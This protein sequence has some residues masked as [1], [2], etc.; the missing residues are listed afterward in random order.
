LKSNLSASRPISGLDGIRALAVVSVIA[1]H[2]HV[3]WLGGGGLGV[4]IFFTLSGFLITTLLL[5][6]RAVTG[7]VSLAKFWGRRLLRLMP[8]LL[9]M[10][11]LVDTVGL[12]IGSELWVNGL[13]ATPSVIFYFAN[14][15]AVLDGGPA[16]LGVFAPL[17]SLS[18]E[19]QF[20][21]VWPLVVMVCAS[22]VRSRRVLGIVGSLIALAAIVNRF[23]LFDGAARDRTFGTDFRIDV[24]LAGALLA[25][26][27]QSG[28]VSL[29]R[30]ASRFAVVPA[31]L[32]LVGAACFLPDV[33]AY[34]DDATAYLYYTVG[35]PLIALSTACIVGF[36]TTHQ[37]SRMVRVLSLK[38]LT[39]LGR[40]SYGMYLWHFPIMVVVVSA[41]HLD[42]DLLFVVS[43]VATVV[44]A[45][46]SWRFVER[47]LS[48]QFHSRLVAQPRRGP[49]ASAEV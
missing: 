23:V 18:V 21:F 41:L 47:P 16:A 38:P 34:G 20:Y 27:M 40:I 28:K 39:Y 2:A 14:W 45:S 11:L 6:E 8:A 7:R 3:V 42:P 33:H 46:L 22:F 29:V 1:A 24:I 5:R 48:R 26:V 35:L 37:S 31:V 19:E 13:A 9:V 12:V 17:W 4:D 15:V 36:V 44:V 30:H 25:I 32:L 10:V 49:T 43:V